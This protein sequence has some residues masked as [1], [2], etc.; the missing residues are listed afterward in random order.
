MLAK[1]NGNAGKG[2]DRFVDLSKDF[3]GKTSMY[4]L[5]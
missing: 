2:L 4:A 3:F 5:N 1:Y